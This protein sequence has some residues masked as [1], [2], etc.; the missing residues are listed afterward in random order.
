MRYVTGEDENGKPIDVLDPLAERMKSIASGAGRDAEGLVSGLLSVNE[1][2]GKDL[3]QSAELKE[4]LIGYVS[5]LLT[6][7]AKATVRR[8]IES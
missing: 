5:Q 2:F 6:D 4:L 8:S 3:L 1:V 7:G